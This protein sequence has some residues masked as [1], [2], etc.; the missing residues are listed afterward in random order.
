MSS[1]RTGHVKLRNKRSS[2]FPNVCTHK[3]HFKGPQRNQLKNKYKRPI[4][5]PTC[6]ENGTIPQSGY[7]PLT[8]QGERK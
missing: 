1:S 4:L 5:F 2:N 3:K 6:N 8:R 7:G